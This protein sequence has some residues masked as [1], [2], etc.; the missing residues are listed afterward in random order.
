[1]GSIS[2]KLSSLLNTRN[3]LRIAVLSVILAAI[4]KLLD[5]HIA[6]NLIVNEDKILQSLVFL[7]IGSTAGGVVVFGL[8]QLKWLTTIVAPEYPGKLVRPKGRLL[9]L[10]LTIGVLGASNTGFYLSALVLGDPGTIAGLAGMQ[11]ILIGLIEFM[12]IKIRKFRSPL[13][14]IYEPNYRYM[15]LAVLSCSFGVFFFSAGVNPSV[16]TEMLLLMGLSILSGAAADYLQKFVLGDGIKNKLDA[17]TFRVWYFGAFS[18]AAVLTL[19][20]YLNSM[21]SDPLLAIWHSIDDGMSHGLPFFLIA[22]MVLAN[23]SIVL[24]TGLVAW[25]TVTE[26]QILA[27]GRLILIFMGVFIWSQLFGRSELGTLPTDPTVIL[28]MIIG[29]VLLVLS[30]LVVPKRIRTK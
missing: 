20:I 2:T 9:V 13:L 21:Y 15:L 17:M 16:K 14:P 26:V 18:I 6:S 5:K 1:M 22:L 7:G 30:Y 3:G 29:A 19:A 24:S 10:V 28:M 23:L 4:Y 11:T 25:K 12:E 8:S 27:T